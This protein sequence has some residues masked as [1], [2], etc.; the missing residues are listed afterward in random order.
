MLNVFKNAGIR[1]GIQPF[2]SQPN[3]ILDF[4]D[5]SALVKPDDHLPTWGAEMILMI[6]EWH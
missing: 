5:S 3:Q 6:I 2:E 4:T 1:K